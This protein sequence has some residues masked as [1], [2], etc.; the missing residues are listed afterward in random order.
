[1]EVK[2]TNNRGKE[3]EGMKSPFRWYRIFWSVVGVEGRIRV[4]PLVKE[5]NQLEKLLKK[6][7]KWKYTIYTAGIR[8]QANMEFFN[9]VCSEGTNYRVITLR[10]IA[11]KV[12]VKI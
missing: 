6:D 9:S 5:E 8:E 1:M 3:K 10:S 4:V 7:Y 2:S 12:L 11:R